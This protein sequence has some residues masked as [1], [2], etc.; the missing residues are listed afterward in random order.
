LLRIFTR[1]VLYAI[2]VVICVSIVAFLLLRLAPGDPARIMVGPD[3]EAELVE[4]MREQMGL[5]DPLWQ[6]YL[7]WAG[8]ALRGD[9]GASL[10]SGQPVVEVM[11]DRLPATL[12]L[13]LAALIIMV[14]AGVPLGVVSAL[15][16]G[17]LIDNITRVGSLL[18]ISI[19]GF[20]FGILCVLVFGWWIPGVLPYYGFVSVTDSLGDALRHTILPATSMAI[21]GIGLI[22]RLTR[23]S[24]L[25]TLSKDYVLGARSLGVPEWRVIWFDTLRNALVPVVTIV[26]LAVGFLLGGSVVIETVFG[27]PGV[28]LLMI[29]SFAIRDYPVVIAIL[30][31]S[32]LLFIIANI[33]VDVIYAALDPKVRRQAER[34]GTR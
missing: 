10:T 21:G 19:P 20:V 32:A 15:R 1:R 27:I 6:Q 34:R 2:P 23:S 22:I 12:Q 13:G 25:D 9:L 14:A 7:S 8:G 16:R 24:M 30:M 17:K 11:L 3:A 28:G 33:L 31:F 26:G 18:G 5:N 4:R 29:Q